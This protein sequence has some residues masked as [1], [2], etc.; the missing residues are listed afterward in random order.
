MSGS[1]HYHLRMPISSAEEARQRLAWLLRT[2][3]LFGSSDSLAV[4]ATFAQ[5]F[6]R[7]RGKHAVHRAQISRWEAGEQPIH[8]GVIAEY[9]RILGLGRAALTTV[10]D[11]ACRVSSSTTGPPML[12]RTT[13][14]S[15][16]R[17]MDALLDKALSE[18]P[19]SGG[20]WDELTTCFAATPGLYLYP[21]R[22]SDLLAER[23]LTELLIADGGEWMRRAEALNR[24]FGIDWMAESIVR[25]C[26]SVVADPS[27][28]V[29]TEPLALLADSNVEYAGQTV[30]AQV[31]HPT[32]EYALSSAW[33]S[34][35]EKVGKHHF[36]PE[37]LALLASAG[38]DVIGDGDPALPLRHTAVELLR[39]LPHGVLSQPASQAV[40]RALAK[41]QAPS[42]TA[43]PD[44]ESLTHKIAGAALSAMPRDAVE[45]DPML[46]S[47]LTDV[48]FQPHT[49]RRLA[50]T[51][52]IG[53]TPYR[54]PVASALT[55][56]LRRRTVL[57]DP[58]LAPAVVRALAI[59]GDPQSRSVL[60]DLVLAPGAPS[61]GCETAAWSLA[62]VAGRSDDRYWRTA[63]AL[64]RDDRSVSRGLVY[65]L[66]LHRNFSALR[67]YA[68][69]VRTPTHL[70]TAAAWW[71]RL[72]T[73]VLAST[74][75]VA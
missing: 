31:I 27:N 10:A 69:D 3:R 51:F 71:L 22:L 25:S 44:R 34:A 42:T 62:H 6:R 5:Q 59:L 26:A 52:L 61:P 57:D 30:I 65:G 17:Q 20:E 50:A 39:R 67:A 53:A 48:L 75:R 43:V 68:A 64:H 45:G 19:M 23:L 29:F 28:Q 56:E 70:R 54:N 72:P 8:L 40:Q 24:L 47:L 49:S 60:E 73:R 55:G 2:N 33:A 15:I 4:G 21:P 38:L 1:G 36:G 9:E 63:L 41:E 12:R 32:N 13:G 16:R 7:S 46:V 58:V 14:G 74:E 37:H 66:G 35:A 18:A 11:F